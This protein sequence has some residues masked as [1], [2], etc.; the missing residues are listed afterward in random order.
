MVSAGV[1][2]N[3]SLFYITT[4]PCPRLDGRSVAFGRVVTGMEVV[5]KVTKS[6][7]I[8]G[9]PVTEIVVKQAGVVGK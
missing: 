4:H 7:S 5:E 1:N 2:R 9:R 8:R 6:Y 3:G